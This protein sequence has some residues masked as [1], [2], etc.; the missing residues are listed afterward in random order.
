MS[1]LFT[2]SAACAATA[3]ALPFIFRLFA[4]AAAR[5]R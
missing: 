5:P 3:L 4:R 1:I 2:V